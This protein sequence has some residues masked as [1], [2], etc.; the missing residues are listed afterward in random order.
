MLRRNPHLSL[1]GT[2][3][4]L[5]ALGVSPAQGQDVNGLY[6]QLRSR[7]AVGDVVTIKDVYGR[8]M[9]GTIR[10]LSRSSVTLMSDNCDRIFPESDI[11]TVTR[12][13]SRWN[14]ALWGFPAGGILGVWLDNGLVREYG[15]EDISVGDS[16]MFIGGAGAIGAATGFVVDAL[17]KRER[18][19]YSKSATG[20]KTSAG[21]WIGRRRGVFVYLRFG[22]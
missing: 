6:E 21:L 16:A 17:I 22:G 10:E 12:R 2:I 18:P 14:G 19:V 5:L 11:E 1:S 7:V 9:R 8:E 4:L 20:T 15:R 13:D 3:T